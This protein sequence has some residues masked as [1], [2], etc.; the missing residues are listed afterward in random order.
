M[1][2]PSNKYV[3]LFWKKCKHTDKRARPLLLHS[4]VLYVVINSLN[5]SYGGGLRYYNCHNFR[6]D[7]IGA[8]DS[9]GCLQS[10]GIAL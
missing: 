10:H 6:E 4:D 7:F 2:E 5:L 3:F 1:L 8:V 9:S